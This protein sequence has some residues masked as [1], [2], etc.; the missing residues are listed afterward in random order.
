MTNP[1]SGAN[2]FL[3]AALVS[4]SLVACNDSTQVAYS[5]FEDI[6]TSGWDSADVVSFEPW[7]SDSLDAAKYAYNMELVFRW[8][9][10]KVDTD[11]PLVVSFENSNGVLKNDTI[12]LNTNSSNKSVKEK[13]GIGET[14]LTLSSD[15]RLTE[16]YTISVYPLLEREYNRGLL[17]VGLVLKQDNK[18]QN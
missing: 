1:L 14:S 4:L 3:S 9:V 11:I 7:P 6:V 16:G 12:I 18:L 13:Y 10:R 15:L 2:V 5:H 8:S 17:N